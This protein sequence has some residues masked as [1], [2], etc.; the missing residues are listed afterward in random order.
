MIFLSEICSP[1]FGVHFLV[2]LL[3]DK[4]DVSEEKL[5]IRFIKENHF[6]VITFEISFDLVAFH[7]TT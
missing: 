5:F 6:H 3:D 2:S 7:A 1:E 4:V